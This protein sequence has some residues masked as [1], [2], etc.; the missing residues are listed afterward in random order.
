MTIKE[1]LDKD[2][3]WNETSTLYPKSTKYFLEW[4]D[5]YKEII[6]WDALFDND[7]TRP[8][9]T[10]YNIPYDFQLGIWINFVKEYNEK[11]NRLNTLLHIDLKSDIKQFF[12][13]ILEPQIK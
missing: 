8:T 10:F 5:K 1:H 13:D 2:N 6:S 4:V 3:F 12:S 11:V 7:P 9:I